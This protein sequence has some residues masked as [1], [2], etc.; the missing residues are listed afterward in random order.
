MGST[1]PWWQVTPDQ[2]AGNMLA[3]GS[4]QLNAI[5]AQDPLLRSIDRMWNANPFREIVPVDWAEIARALRTVWMLSLARP[6]ES[7]QSAGVLNTKMW[8]SS[9]DRSYMRGQCC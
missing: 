4:K 3:A 2:M 7:I 5:L 6:G 9:I 8:Q 1:E